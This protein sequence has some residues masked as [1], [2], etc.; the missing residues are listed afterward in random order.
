MKK[1]WIVRLMLILF[2]MPI[3]LFNIWCG[4]NIHKLSTKR[5]QLKND[6]ARANDILYGL[7]SVTVWRDDL[8]KIA[9]DRIQDFTFTREQEEA[10]KEQISKLLNAVITE[11]DSVIERDDNDFNGKLRKLAV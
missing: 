10:L 7:L 5:I 3:L 2:T 11:A 8:Q 1:K 6:Y 9:S 4:V